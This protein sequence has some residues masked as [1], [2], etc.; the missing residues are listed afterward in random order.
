MNPIYDLIVI[1][2][3]VVMVLVNLFSIGDSHNTVSLWTKLRKKIHDFSPLGRSP[4]LSSFDGQAR[5][6]RD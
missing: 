2:L 4:A 1:G 5:L 3:V 6:S